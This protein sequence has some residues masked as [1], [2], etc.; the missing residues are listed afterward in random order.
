MDGTAGR[1]VVEASVFASTMNDIAAHTREAEASEIKLVFLGDVYDL[2]RTERWFEYPLEARPWGDAPSEEALGDIFEAVVAANA[3]MLEAISGSLADRFGFPVEPERVYVPGN[4]DRLV[5]GSATLRRR[6][7]ETLGIGTAPD[8]ALFPHHVL[9]EEHGVFARHGHEWDQFSFAGSQTLDAGEQIEVPPEDYQRMAIG[10]VMACE[11]ASRLGPLVAQVLGPDHPSVD[12]IAER[13]RTITDVRPLQ[14]AMQWAAWQA[15]QFEERESDAINE[16]IRIAAKDVREIPF[17]RRWMESEDE[18]GIDRADLFQ[19]LTRALV[20]FEF[21]DNQR[22]LGFIDDF[23]E[24]Q[25][26][27]DADVPSREFERL[28]RHPAIGEHVYYV[29]YGHTHAAVQRPV[30]VL[31]RPPALRYRVYFNTGTWRPVH[32]RLRPPIGGFAS[33]RE[34]TY[35]LVYRPGERVSGGSFLPYPAVESWTGV[36]VGPGDEKRARGLVS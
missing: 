4:H 25:R 5:N 24:G 14:A 36:A 32:R 22:V 12:A 20:S 33:W 26:D 21:L 16:A 8:D 31:G 17:V 18:W 29:L 7:R 3:E 2:W 15:T 35:V 34:M 9:D 6:V 28:D 30:G 19:M 10:D 11:F 13:V 27:I 1:E 23:S